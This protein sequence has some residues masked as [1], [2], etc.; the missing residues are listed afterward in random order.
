MK[1]YPNCVL[2]CFLICVLALPRASSFGVELKP[3]IRAPVLCD[4]APSCG[5]AISLSEAEASFIRGEKLLPQKNREP[6]PPGLLGPVRPKVKPMI[7]GHICDSADVLG[8]YYFWAPM[9]RLPGGRQAFDDMIERLQSGH[10]F[11]S[12]VYV[13]ASHS[14]PHERHI[15]LCPVRTIHGRTGPPTNCTTV[16]IITPSDVWLRAGVERSSCYLAG[17]IRRSGG[18]LIEFEVETARVPVELAHSIQ[19]VLVD[20]LLLEVTGRSTRSPDGLITHIELLSDSGMRDSI[21]LPRGWRESIEFD[22][23]IAMIDFGVRV[24]GDGKASVCRQAVDS[25]TEYVGLNDAQRSA[26]VEKFNSSLEDGIRRSCS[27]FRKLDAKR[28]VCD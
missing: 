11:E 5:S 2:L 18:I 21:V 20:E 23:S 24:Y 14:R 28:I 1:I 3:A 19:D 6:L 16:A 13:E 27:T 25:L 7:D 17:S 4:D 12:K 26:Y 22:V 9:E 10:P 8:L 15:A